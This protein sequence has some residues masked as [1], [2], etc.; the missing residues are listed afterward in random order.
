[1]RLLRCVGT[2]CV[3]FLVCAPAGAWW[4]AEW[5]LRKPVEISLA[6]ALGATPQGLSDVPMLLRLHSGNFPQF[7]LAADD[8]ADFRLVTG[9]DQHVLDH[10]VETFDPVAQM[11]LIW[12]RMPRL[13]VASSQRIY[14]Y[15][16]N[17]SVAAADHSARIYDSH[18]VAAFQFANPD[19]LLIDSSGND[20]QASGSLVSVPTSLIGG[21]IRLAGALRIADAPHLAMLAAQ[22]WTISTWL[23]I[24]ALPSS[25]MTL[26][27]RGASAD[28]LSLTLDDTRLTL[29]VGGTAVESSVPFAPQAWTHVAVVVAADAVRLLLDGVEVATAQVEPVSMTG[30]IE[31]GDSDYSEQVLDL[32]LD[33]LR[34]ADV[35][36]DTT[37]IAFAAFVEGSRNEDIVTYGLDESEDSLSVTQES[38]DRGLMSIVN[39][40]FERQDAIVEQFVIGVCAIMAVLATLVIVTKAVQLHRC[41]RATRAFLLIYRAWEGEGTD[42]RLAMPNQTVQF[43]AS[44]LFAIYNAGQME[45]ARRLLRVP[46]DERAI[47]SEKSRVTLRAKL[48]A[49]ATRELDGL[50]SQLVLLTIAISGGPF[51]GLF[52]TVIGVMMTFSAI[53]ASGDVNIAAIAPGM[54]SA[55]LATV[56]GLGVAI[57]ALFGYN[58]LGAQVQTLGTEMLV[59]SE[60]YVAELNE[61]YG[62]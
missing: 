2:L 13:D 18:T 54:A 57:P 22:G 37:Q 7:L 41:R 1:M 62:V 9:D 40:V 38:G 26:I 39:Q 45:I 6:A 21:G 33:E 34:I 59:F 30:A 36:R 55:L 12:V 47:L 25:T 31:I 50:N 5:N 43:S 24:N 10:V 51:I 48:D 16:D 53:A 29:R 23:R 17:P 28:G 14:L 15:F 52:G 3:L 11:A 42:T 35:A 60:E 27:A 58:F 8:G 56:A 49:V 61:R 20:S 44:P 32:E 19:H 46:Q 4:S